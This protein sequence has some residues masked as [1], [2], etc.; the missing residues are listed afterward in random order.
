MKVRLAVIAEGANIAAGQKLNI[1]GAF[2]AL[3][4]PSFPVKHPYMVL[5][6]RLEFEYEDGGKTHELGIQVHDPDGRIP[7][8][9]VK[10]L[11]VAPVKPGHFTYQDEVLP[12]VGVV[13]SK[14]G[15]IAFVILWNGVEH[16]RVPLAFMHESDL[17]P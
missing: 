15:S 12:F 6:L 2:S 7:F 16:A 14:A 4:A 17:T 5:V 1:L 13:A 8:D 10:R 11:E 3:L 9:V